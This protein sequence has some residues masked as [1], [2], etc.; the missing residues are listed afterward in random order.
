MNK[1]NLRIGGVMK[2]FGMTTFFL[3]ILAAVGCQTTGAEVNR[4]QTNLVDKSVFEGEWWYAQTIVD[5]DGDEAAI[6]GV[7]QGQ[8]GWADMGVDNAQSGSVAR[9]RWVIDQNYLFAFRAYEL[10]DGGNDDGHSP[11]FRGQ[12]LAVFAIQDHVDVRYDYNTYTGQRSNVLVEDTSDRRWYERQFV[13]VDWSQ[14][15]ITSFYY[16]T[17]ADLFGSAIRESQPFFFQEGAHPEFPASWQ[18]QFIRIADDPTYKFA[19]EWPAEMQ[20]SVHYMSFVTQE[21]YSPGVNCLIYDIPCQT[22]AVTVRNSFLRVPPNHEYAVET[23]SHR[24]FDRFGTFRT[25]QRTYVRGGAD[26]ATLEKRCSADSDCGS[27]GYC[28]MNYFSDPSSPGYIEGLTG[29]GVCSGGLTD[30]YGELDFLTFYRPRHNHFVDHLTEQSC[31]ADYQCDGRFGAGSNGSVCDRS[32][33][34]C[35]VPMNERETRKV[36]YWLSPGFPKH[37]VKTAFQTIGDWNGSFMAGH[38][39]RMG[40]ALPSSSGM[41]CQSENPVDYC[42]CGSPDDRGDGTCAYKYDPFQSPADAMAAGVT[43][44]YDCYVQAPEGYTEPAHPTSFDEYTDAVFGYEFV[45]DEC[46]FVLNANSCDKD[47]SKPCE[48]LGDLRYQ[49]FNYIQ[50]G[51]LQFGGVSLPLVDPTTGELI[52]SN[53][54]MAAPSA[55][56]AVGL[57]IDYF[58]VLRGEPGAADRYFEGEITRDYFANLGKVERPVSYAPSGSDGYSIDDPTRPG[59]P[60]MTG[61]RLQ[62]LFEDRIE[63]FQRLAPTPEGRANILSDRMHTLAGTPQETHLL[64]SMGPDGAELMFGQVDTTRIPDRTSALA[65]DMIGTTS[66]FR[67]GFMDGMMRDRQLW[68]KLGQYNMDPPM[69]PEISNVVYKYWADLFADKP[70]EEA[71]IRMMQLYLRGIMHHEMGHSVGLRHNFGASYDRDSYADG[72]YNVVLRDDLALPSLFDPEY[73]PDGDGFQGGEDVNRFYADLRDVRNRRH[74]AGLGMTMTNSV[75]DYDGDMSTF[76]PKLGYYDMAAANWNAFGL[77]EAFTS[78]PHV[79]RG[80]SLDDVVDARTPRQFMKDYRGGEACNVDSDCPFSQGRVDQPVFQRCIENVRVSRLPREC[81]SGE[82]CQCSPFYEDII[83]Y[84]IGTPPYDSSDSPEMYPVDY[85][86]CTDDRVQDISWCNRFDAG[87]SFTET[88]DFYRRRFEETYPTSYY[89]RFRDTSLRGLATLG[90][91]IDAAKIYQHLFFRYFNEPGF[92]SEAGPLGFNDQFFA[93]IDAMNWMTELVAMPDAGSY[94]YDPDQEVYRYMGETMDMGD[95]NVPLGIG[96]PT[97]SKYQDGYWGFFRRERAGVF[98]DKFYALLALA[99]RD[100]GFSFTI[101]ERYFINF[102]DLFPVEMTEFFGGLITDQPRW[103]QPRVEMVDGS[104]QLTY[105]NWYRGTCDTPTGRQPCRGSQEDVYPGTAIAGTTPELLRDWATVLAL[106]Q[107]PVFYDTSFEQR[108]SVFK[109]QAGDSFTLPDTQTDGTTTCAYG[110]T[111]LPG[112]SHDTG[113]DSVDADYVIYESDRFHTGYV[114]VKVKPR[115][116]YNLEEEQLGFQLLTRMVQTQERIRTLTALPSPTADELDELHVL[117]EQ[118]TSNESFLEYLI[119]IQRQYGISAY[120][121]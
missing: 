19:D 39:G 77:V 118:L 92:R 103:Y 120:F 88:I 46:A 42:Y 80:D 3:A 53:A 89:R 13:R 18:P 44:P 99:I 56:S 26:L 68:Q 104:P 32:A 37:L 2:P 54:N 38:R 114:A 4:V 105:L 111:A 22:A 65:P 82:N 69:A 52:V 60:V 62:H 14:N 106:A 84:S 1:Q 24:E 67:D 64:E 50:H 59:M 45:G 55:E 9:I 49:F 8:M 51:N 107:F 11:D 43:D 117:T 6:M 108:L 119:D 97:W 27:G 63:D 116:T 121:L 115:L 41:A 112:T 29:V 17:G 73:D 23:E 57:A 21:L 66:P 74:E 85:L 78:D 86:F 113:C 83:D 94:E 25:Y 101:D 58:P 110:D 76:G 93:S 33:R 100:W 71:A 47:P 40:L 91:V 28:D 30:D 87:E 35:T 10:I 48:E 16:L 75:M 61:E 36:N 15:L 102:F 98:M 109:I 79:A 81:T 5:V 90:F 20:D 72:Y 12:P 34:R 95:M 31:T 96:F 70:Q 7:F